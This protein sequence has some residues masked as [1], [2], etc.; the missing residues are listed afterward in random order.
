MHDRM[1]CVRQE[2]SY[3][4]DQILSLSPHI[5]DRQWWSVCEASQHAVM[6]P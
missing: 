6:V 3:G 5:F 1:I 2:A 4:I